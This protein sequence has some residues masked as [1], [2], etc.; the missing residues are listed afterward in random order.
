MPLKQLKNFK[1]GLFNMERFITEIFEE[2]QE[3]QN[4]FFAESIPVLTSISLEIAKTFIRGGK[5][6]IFG[7]GG[8]AADAQHIAS[9]FVSRFKME[10]PPLPA[11]ALTTDSSI[12]TSIGSDFSFEDIFLKQL[13]AIAQ[14]IDIVIGISISGNCENVLKGLKYAAKNGIKSIGF[15]GKDGGKMKGLCDII[16]SVDSITTA[17]VQEIHIQAA[18][19]VC[20]MVD[21][22]MFGRLSSFL[23]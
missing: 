16:F 1:L 9:N 18:H 13:Q 8:S 20:E 7:N 5:L 21:E 17:R 12:I 14:N 22:I 6:L 3:T 15:T 23:D 4:R 19:I 11:I 10:R 2:M